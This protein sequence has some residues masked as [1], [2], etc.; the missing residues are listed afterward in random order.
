MSSLQ[1]PFYSKEVRWFFQA[2]PRE[3]EF[4]FYENESFVRHDEST[5]TDFYL[6]MQPHDNISYKIR[7]GR[8]EIKLRLGNVETLEFPNGHKGKINRWVKWS[9]ALKEKIT[10]PDLLFVPDENNFTALSKKRKLITFE[11]LPNRKIRKPGSGPS[12]GQGC[13]VELTDLTVN[14]KHWFSFGFEVFGSRLMM[15]ENFDLVTRKVLEEIPEPV[16]RESDSYSYPE[17]LVSVY[18]SY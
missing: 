10:H 14:K 4:W 13:Q 5:R 1:S 17:F 9:L 18:P 8:T 6:T 15:E 11:I 16:L 12:P 2:P 7:E 3:L